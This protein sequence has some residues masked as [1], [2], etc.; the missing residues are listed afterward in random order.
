MSDPK[1]SP[2]PVRSFMQTVR[3]TSQL[4]GDAGVVQLLSE[5][6]PMVLGILSVASEMELTPEW[7]AT[8]MRMLS[9][10][11]FEQ[12]IMAKNLANETASRYEA[13]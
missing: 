10:V 8:R 12:K 3:S 11:K 13:D 6:L 4:H 5:N 9:S 7:Q 2:F 1:L